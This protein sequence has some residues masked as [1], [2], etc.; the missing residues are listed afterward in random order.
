[1]HDTLSQWNRQGKL[2]NTVWLLDQ[3]A[4]A[5][6][7]ICGACERIRNTPL[8][9]SY[10]AMKRG[11]I[12]L[13]VLVAPWAIGLEMGWNGLPIMLVAFSFLIGVELTAEAVEEPF[14]HE[15][16]DLELEVYC[17]TIESFVN[18]TL[19]AVPRET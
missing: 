12:A 10:R 7:D 9:S 19:V 17:K 2:E 16:D 3:H 5:L 4:R 6:M 8:A 13:Y 1:V 14:G 18:A 15:G 11:A